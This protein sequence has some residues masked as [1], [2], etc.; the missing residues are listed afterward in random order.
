MERKFKTKHDIREI[1]NPSYQKAVTETKSLAETITQ[2]DANAKA[3]W[4]N[5]RVRPPGVPGMPWRSFILALGKSLAPSVRGGA[6]T[7]CTDGWLAF[8]ASTTQ[9]HNPVSMTRKL[10]AISNKISFL[11]PATQRTQYLTDF[12]KERVDLQFSLSESRFRALIP[13]FH[14]FRVKGQN[15][16]QLLY[17]ERS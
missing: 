12:D 11:E 2:R 9:T 5:R 1:Q 6:S 10:Y 15:L 16:T 13:I 7:G 3:N 17:N 14:R 8:I 4:S